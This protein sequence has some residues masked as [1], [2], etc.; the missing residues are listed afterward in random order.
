MRGT[1]AALGFPLTRVIIGGLFKFL[2]SKIERLSPPLLTP[3]ATATQWFRDILLS[4]KNV[5]SVKSILEAFKPMNDS[6][7]LCSLSAL[8]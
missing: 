7:I 1:S 3:F 8:V 2:S 5:V 6:Q 4:V